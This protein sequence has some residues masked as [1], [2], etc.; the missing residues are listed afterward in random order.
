VLGDGKRRHF[1]LLR[2]IEQL[3]DAAGTVQQRELCVEVEVNEF[4]HESFPFDG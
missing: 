3:V 4:S 2:L 1:E